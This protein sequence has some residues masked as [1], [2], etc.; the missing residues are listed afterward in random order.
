MPRTI[1]P[2]QRAAKQA[3]Q[4]A[5]GDT[6]PEKLVKYIPGETLAFTVPVAAALGSDHEVWLIAMLIVAALGTPAY[7]WNSATSLPADQRPLT[8][9]Y[10]LATVAFGCWAIGTCPSVANLISVDD[11]VAGVILAAAVFLVP[12]LDG[13]LTNLLGPK[14]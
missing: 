8:H 6:L 3:G 12:L 13:V 11:V 5:T 9:F 10:V 2:P 1:V 14:N 7:L 4:P